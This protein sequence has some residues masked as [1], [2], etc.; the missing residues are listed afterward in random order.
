MLKWI[1][2]GAVI[3][4]AVLV[5]ILTAWQWGVG[6]LLLAAI[7]FGAAYSLGV[8]TEGWQRWSK[9]LYSDDPED[10]DHWSRTGGK[11]KR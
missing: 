5:G 3:V 1:S 2:V 10:A 4:A 11:R 7:V 9:A 6:V 8:E